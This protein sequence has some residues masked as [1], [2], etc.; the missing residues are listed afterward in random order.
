MTY[1]A[2]QAVLHHWLAFG[3]AG[4]LAAEIALASGEPSRRQVRL[5]ARV[6]ALYG[7]CFILL[8]TVG[9]FRVHFGEKGPD[10]YYGNPVFWLKLGALALVLLASLPPTLA[11]IR[12]SRA[13]RGGAEAL[14]DKTE[15]IRIRRFLWAE[16]VLFLPV[17]LLAAMMA[18]GIGL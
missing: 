2:A 11:F 1:Y 14:P 7:A 9:F 15:I 18:R 8:V 6:D 5:L 17:P 4:F 16:A 10:A 12:W 13:M 3:M